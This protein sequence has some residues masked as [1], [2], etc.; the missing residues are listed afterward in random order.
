MGDYTNA[1]K[2]YGKAAEIFA[3]IGERMLYAQARENIGIIHVWQ[4]SGGEE[5]IQGALETYRELGN[6]D[7]VAKTLFNLYSVYSKAGDSSAENM[8]QKILS[9]LEEHNIDQDIEAGILLG[10]LPQDVGNKTSLIVFRERLQQLRAFYEE[11]NESIGLGRSLLQL[12][13]VEQKLGNFR[14]MRQYAKGAE[15]Y[16]DRIP[17]PLRISFHSD[18]GFFLFRPENPEEGMDHFWQAFDLAEGV[19]VDQQSNLITVIQ[20]MI[21][22]AADSIDREKQ[23]RKVQ[24]VLENTEDTDIL[25]ICQEILN[26]LT[27]INE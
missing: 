2:Y 23:R 25:R 24:R 11:R 5:D 27:P 9:L 14:R 3:G 7:Q 13:R 15:A 12:A 20:P 16:A 1:L 18:L 22:Q 17:L 10:I 19:A 26:F 6:H 4:G 21:I 8:V